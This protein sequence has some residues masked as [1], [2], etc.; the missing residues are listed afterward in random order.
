MTGLFIARYYKRKIRINR[1]DC[2]KRNNKMPYEVLHFSGK[3]KS[4]RPQ[5]QSCGRGCV[6][7]Y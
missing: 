6:M 1:T 2:I 4:P 5:E 3:Q 7:A